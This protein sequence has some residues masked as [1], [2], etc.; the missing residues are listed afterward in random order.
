MIQLGISTSCFYPLYLEK[1]IKLLGGAGV[2]NIE[3][4]FNAP[5][6]L[7]LD[8]IKQIRNYLEEYGMRVCAAHPFSSGFEPFYFFTRYERRF[9]DGAEEYRKLFQAA[10]LLACPYLVFHGDSNHSDLPWDDCFERYHRL[11][12]IG[13]EMGVMLLQENVSRCKSGKPE[14]IRAM[15]NALGTEAGF[16][17]DLKQVIRAQTTDDEMFDAMGDRL[18]HLHL[19]DSAPDQDCL[20]PGKGRRDL[21]TVF[22]RLESSK[23]TI[24]GIIELYRHNYGEYDEVISSYRFL[25]KMLNNN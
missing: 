12:Q 9:L 20:P 25:Q 4:F 3:I 19:S 11:Y 7:N 2:S 13:R 5:S 22:R 14:F 18:F 1:S 17:L 21:G 10:Q 8:F 6:E 23:R 15:R 24:T 16:V